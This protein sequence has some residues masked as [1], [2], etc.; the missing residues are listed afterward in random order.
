MNTKYHKSLILLLI[1]SV[2]LL[3]YVNKLTA[4]E[5]NSIA[6]KI[7]NDRPKIKY[8]KV[9]YKA[10]EIPPPKP[11][12]IDSKDNIDDSNI[13]IPESNKTPDNLKF[14]SPSYTNYQGYD[15]DSLVVLPGHNNKKGDNRIQRHRVF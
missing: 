3:T 14:N 12:K 4:D 2:L 15:N 10:K 8:V 7:N 9:T 11:I 1:S 6:L 5:R 13:Y